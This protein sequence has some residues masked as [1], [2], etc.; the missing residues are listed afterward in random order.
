M[1]GHGV[2]PGIAIGTAITF[3]VQAIEAPRYAITDPAAE[4]LRFDSAVERVRE[5][6]EGM[7]DQT[8]EELGEH[9]AAIFDSHIEILRDATFRSEVEQRLHDER[10][11]VEY[12]VDAQIGAYAEVLAQVGD[13]F[14]KERSAD[15]VDLGKRILGELLDRELDSL[16]HLEAP[17]I[18][19][20]H[21]LSPAETVNMDMPNTLGLATDGGGPTSHS[22]ILARA[23]EIPAVVG[24][25]FAGARVAPGNTVIVDGASGFVIIRPSETTLAFYEQEKERQ[26]AERRAYIGEAPEGL[27][28][29]LDGVEVPTLVNIELPIEADL[30]LK[31]RCQGVGLFRTEYLFMN[32]SN[33]PSE[34]EQ[35]DAY[36]RVL[37]A[38]NPA[39]VTIRTLDMG[40]DKV[41]ANVTREEEANPQLGWR[42]IRLCL[43]R[44][45]IFKAQLRALYRAS[46][47]G[48]LQVMF[49]LI[50][51]VDEYREASQIAAE[52]REDLHAR[53]VAHDPTVK[54]GAMIE[55]PAAVAVA[56]ELAQECAFFSLGT[57]DLIQY[58]LAVDRSNERTAH[59][60]RPCDPSVLRLVKQTLDAASK[61]GIPCS[62]CGEMAGDPMYTELLLGMGLRSFS[63][64]AVSLPLVRAEI[65][66]TKL[67]MAKRFAN[68][69]LRMGSCSEISAALVQ[70][71]ENRATRKRIRRR[72]TRPAARLQ[73]MQEG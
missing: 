2:S 8:L 46:V 19:I 49:P 39:S 27:C 38:M 35:Y 12:L 72:E 9:H 13:P 70:R 65:A 33:L 32:R 11:N 30:S 10:L 21:D 16:E 69:L 63:M 57:N 41:V 73:R 29:T 45:D 61:A 36:R 31:E 47:H 14:F 34:E 64:S 67:T 17:C 5:S 3:H 43:D 62:A 54:I 60:Y 42:S 24:L 1:R 26:D 53:G 56:N 59:L 6:L 23:F 48:A 58:C 50:S 52:V 68:K 37:E 28:V 66:N 22:A 25:R 51:G 4:L 71:Y 15:F 20:A 44:P 40:G 18:V 55:V 7:R